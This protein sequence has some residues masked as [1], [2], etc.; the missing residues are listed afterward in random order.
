MNTTTKPNTAGRWLFIGLCILLLVQGVARFAVQPAAGH[1]LDDWSYSAQAG[2]FPSACATLVGGLRHPLRPFLHGVQLSVHRWLGDCHAGYIS[3]SLLGYSL[4][5]VLFVLFVRELTD[6]A[7]TALVAGLLFALLPNLCGHFHWLCVAIAFGLF[8]QPMY[9]LS[10][11]CLARYA[12][13]GGGWNLAVATTGYFFGIGNYEV[14]VFLPAAYAV[15]LWG[16]GWK[17]WFWSMFPFGFALTVYAAWRLT[18]GFGYGWSWFGI[19]PQTAVGLSLWELKHTLAGVVSWWGGVNWWSAVGDGTRGFVELSWTTVVLLMVANAALLAVLGW[20]MSKMDAGDH[21]TEQSG[22]SPF[23]SG[24]L[25]LFG[26]VW[27]FATYIP[28]FL[29]YLVPRINYL[30]GAGMA[31]LAALALGCVRMDRWL[32]PLLLL[33]FAGM[34]VAE[35]DT[36]NWAD[37]IRFQQN[38][39]ATMH[40]LRGD[41]ENS[42]ILWLDTRELSQRMTPDILDGNRH[43]IDT[44]AEYRN[45]GFLRGFAPSAMAELILEGKPGPQVILDVEYGAHEEDGV[46]KWHERYNPDKPFETPMERVYRLDVFAAGTRSAADG[47]D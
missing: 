16:R 15:L 41:W 40:E 8:G 46:L 20:A 12:R 3:L 27:V 18:F 11:W 29:G 14:G 37:S 45:A 47:N 32:V 1:V 6:K 28:G 43:H 38:M 30:P 7:R 33:A 5:L 10:A 4:A 35:G 31:L 26:F 36:K 22:V 17:K 44:I 23:G 34:V 2:K 13:R 39:L 9:L 42:E 21:H 25:V 24:K 19:P